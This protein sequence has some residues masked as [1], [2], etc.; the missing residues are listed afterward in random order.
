MFLD[1]LRL[2]QAEILLKYHSNRQEV[3]QMLLDDG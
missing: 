1:S 2:S 3:I